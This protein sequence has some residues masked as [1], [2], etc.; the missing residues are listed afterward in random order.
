ML[1]DVLDAPVAELAVGDDIDVLQHFLN[2]GPLHSCQ[3][4][5]SGF[6]LGLARQGTDLVLFQTILEDVLDNETARLAQSDLVPHALQSL[7]DVLHD[8]GRRVRPAKFEQLLPDMACIAM[9]DSLGDPTEQLVHHDGLVLLW[10]R[11]EGLLD[12]MAAK[13]I[14]REVEC[15]ATDRFSNLDDLLRSSVLEASLDQEITKPVDHERVGLGHDC[16]DNVVLLLGGADLQLLL[17]EDGG[18]LVVVADNFVDD[19]LPVAC[20]IAIEEPAIVERLRR[21]QKRLY[22]GARLPRRTITLAKPGGSE[23]SP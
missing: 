1:A 9:D 8:L 23:N 22:F 10:H 6:D 21:R 15:V 7:V 2:A 20:N 3:H 14:H 16:L 17:Q 11:I 13:R 19:V 5:S 18:L 12:D 4:G